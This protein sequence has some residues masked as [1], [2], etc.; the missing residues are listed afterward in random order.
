MMVRALLTLFLICGLLLPVTGYAQIPAQQPNSEVVTQ[1]A[2]NDSVSQVPALRPNTELDAQPIDEVKPVAA[3]PKPEE[4]T[5]ER[6][7]YILVNPEVMVQLYW[8]T[9]L[10]NY[11]DRKH[12]VSYL[13]YM[14]CPLLRN[15]LNDEFK[16][17]QI[18]NTTSDYLR[19]YAKKFPT[20]VRFIQPIA[21][22]NFNVDK[23]F[24]TISPDTQYLNTSAI[25]FAEFRKAMAQTCR[26][27]ELQSSLIPDSAEVYL[28]SP[29]SITR[30][31]MTP[32]F[33]KG[34]LDYLAKVGKMYPVKLKLRERYAF[35]EFRVSL[36][37]VDKATQNEY[38]NDLVTSAN[39][40]ARYYGRLDGYDVYADD[41]LTLP[42]FHYVNE[43]AIS[44][45]NLPDRYMKIP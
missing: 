23:G 43:R 9:G 44:Y 10:Q 26:I 34:Y 18:L 28:N 1:P 19:T 2:K 13:R 36:Y 7:E 11:K 17:P 4:K 3:E 6:D 22:D 35:I 41:K 15:F 8:R 24:F 20:R 27:A 30:L 32:E 12:I 45:I 31:P 25:E 33:A 39:G 5:P 21:L 14:Q 42:L 37:G 29:F 40:T 38:F 16:L